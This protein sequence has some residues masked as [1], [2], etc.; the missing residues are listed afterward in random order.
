MPQDIV[1]VR[2]TL[3]SDRSNLLVTARIPRDE[4]N[5]NTFD[6]EVSVSINTP[7]VAVPYL[8]ILVHHPLTVEINRVFACEPCVLRIKVRELRK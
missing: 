7:N 2:R 3:G 5:R 6:L 8:G 1:K 4:E